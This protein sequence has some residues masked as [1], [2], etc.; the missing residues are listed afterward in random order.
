[1]LQQVGP[2][3][4]WDCCPL[5]C[6]SCTCTT[7]W[8]PHCLTEILHAS[9]GDC[10][11][12]PSDVTAVFQSAFFPLYLM[13]VV[14]QWWRMDTPKDVRTHHWETVIFLSHAYFLSHWLIIVLSYFCRLFLWMGRQGRCWQGDD[15][16]SFIQSKRSLVQITSAG[17]W[18]SIICR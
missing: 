14:W 17:L 18:F 7:I 15:S 13:R 9:W 3:T 16:G 11:Y 1:M 5:G 12:L 2:C 8:L 4:D 10:T 6:C